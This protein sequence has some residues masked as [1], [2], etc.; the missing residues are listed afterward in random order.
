MYDVWGSPFITTFDIC[1]YDNC[2]VNSDFTASQTN[3]CKGETINFTNTSTGAT[4]YE[5][6]E[7]GIAFSTATDT[8]RTFNTAGTYTISLIADSAS[9]SDS[10][11]VI[12]TVN[13]LPVITVTPSPGVVCNY[14]DTVMLI[15]SGAANY[16]WSPAAGLNTTT[17]DTVL[18]FP[19]TDTTYTVTGTNIYGCIDS[20]TVSVQLST[21][22]PVASFSSSITSVCEGNTVTFNNTSTDATG[23]SWWFPGGTTADTTVQNPVVTYNT[24]GIFDVTLTAL[25][26]STDSTITMTGY[27]TV[28]PTYTTSLFDTICEGDSI[29]LPGGAFADTSGIYYDTSATVNGCDSIVTTTLTVNSVDTITTS[30]SICFGDSILLGGDYQTDTGIYYDTD[31]SSNGCDSVVVTTLTVNPLPPMPTVTVN[32][33][34]LASS[35]ANAY[36]WYFYDTLIAG[37]TSQFYTAT[38]TGYYSVMVADVNGCWSISDPYWVT[39]TSINEIEFLSNLNIYPN[40]NTGEFIIEMNFSK[41]Q[42]VEIKLFYISG[43]MIYSENLKQFKGAYFKRINIK[44]LST[45]VYQLQIK[46]GYGVVNK[47]VVVE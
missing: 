33:S 42:D 12:I 5:W 10:S 7:D 21:V 36:Q 26:C 37:A 14:G 43:Q 19:S 24:S 4:S 16:T 41:S 34:Q 2:N 25:G 17:G 22:N 23:F 32:G 29:Q 38:Q 27:I 35:P 31:T 44:E 28:N 6:Q 20:T 3:I 40:P 47:K 46:T 30:E 9:C 1:I 18:A 45:G 39:V 11:G 15:A 13:P 8:S